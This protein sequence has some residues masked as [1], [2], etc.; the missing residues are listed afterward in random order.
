MHGLK[1]LAFLKMVLIAFSESPTYFENNYGPFMPIKFNFDSVAM[2]L[3]IIV[4][5]QPGG[6]YKRTPLLGSMF[7]L[8]NFSGYWRGK[9][10]AF[11]M[12]FFTCSY[13]PI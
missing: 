9:Y 2:A 4:L 1:A 7:Q 11:F 5:L 10:V 13:P 8:L 3:A 6:P 12:L